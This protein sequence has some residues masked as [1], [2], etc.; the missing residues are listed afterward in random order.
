[1]SDKNTSNKSIQTNP[2]LNTQS[3]IT[4]II[5]YGQR[6]YQGNISSNSICTNASHSNLTNNENSNS[7]SAKNNNTNISLPSLSN[8]SNQLHLNQLVKYNSNQNFEAQQ[9]YDN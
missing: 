7:S 1:M 4:D 2:K 5:S 8:T 3:S 9:I 6:L